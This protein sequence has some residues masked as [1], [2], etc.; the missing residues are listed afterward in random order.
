[1]PSILVA[2]DNTN[3]QKMVALAFK[4]R[5]IKVVAVGNGEAAV[6]RMP[7]MMPDVVLADVFMPVRNGYEVCEFVKKDPRFAHI[8]V[9][10]LVGAFDPL[11]EKEAR[12]V[13]AD[14]VL[15]KPFVPPDPLIAMVTSALEM[16][17]RVAAENAKAKQAAAAPPKPEVVRKNAP[18]PGAASQGDAGRAY[19]TSAG[20]FDANHHSAAATDAGPAAVAAPP[21]DGEDFDSASTSADWRRS[22]RNFE[23][24]ADVANQVAFASEGEF[25]GMFPSEEGAPPAPPEVAAKPALSVAFEAP[26][27]ASPAKSAP[28][29]N[30]PGP[31]PEIRSSPAAVSV[32]EPAS[33]VILEQ[34]VEMESEEPLV[35]RYSGDPSSSEEEPDV[36]AAET[37]EAAEPAVAS[38]APPDWALEAG[39]E[40]D[41]TA[42]ESALAAVNESQAAQDDS[43]FEAEPAGETPLEPAPPVQPAGRE[44]VSAPQASTSVPA[45]PHFD[46]APEDPAPP[47]GLR[48]PSLIE[49]TAVRVTPEALLEQEEPPTSA[50][51]GAVR[52]EVPPLYS[53]IVPTEASAVSEEPAAEEVRMPEFSPGAFQPD[54]ATVDAV[55]QMILQKIEPQLHDLLSQGV[56]T[57]LVEN[58]VQNELAKRQK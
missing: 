42:D 26:V 40:V 8:P 27:S 35:S 56:L 43:F 34:A 17:P 20:E 11:D 14:G 47:L 53:I 50:T 16:N 1:V 23:V 25:G 19:E 41:A 4:E 38:A 7:E 49:D 5:G 13:G 48:D 21:G 2:D 31:A 57:P 6:R 39:A 10:L 54:A 51:Y 33:P 45:A 12:R 22:A 28:A 3:I 30:S 55:V 9:I 37:T 15:K 44:A 58:L 52:E 24:P 18:A 36:E 46:I 29:A 32:P